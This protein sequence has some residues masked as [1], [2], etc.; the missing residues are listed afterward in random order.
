[1]LAHPT[2]T[3]PTRCSV[4]CRGHHSRI[5]LKQSSMAPTVVFITGANRGIGKGLVQQY[6]A[7]PNHTVI[8]TVRDPASSKSLDELPRGEGSSLIVVK[9]DVTKQAD[10]KEAVAEIVSKGIDHLDIVIAN[11]GVCY[12]W[13]KVSEVTIE[14]LQGHFVPNVHG[15][16]FTYQ[17]TLPLLRKSTNG[18]WITIGSCSAW[19]ENQLDMPNAAYATSKVAAHWLTKAIHREEPELTAFPIDPGWVQTDL[20]NHGA[21]HFGFEAAPLSAEKSTEGIVKVVGEATRESHGGKLIQ[22]DGAMLAW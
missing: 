11:A 4:F 2:L 3:E 12:A 18:K 15:L 9:L 22:W 14:D 13:P 6:L 8:G 17:A 21:H 20:G 1:M 16:L 7:K 5:P 10:A 19:L